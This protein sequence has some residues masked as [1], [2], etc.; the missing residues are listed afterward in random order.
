MS[1][2]AVTVAVGLLGWIAV[3]LDWA[4]LAQVAT[5]GAWVLIVGA[6]LMHLLTIPLK[7]GGWRC[8][9]AASSPDAA[10]VGTR[11]MLSPVMVGAL[12]NLV[13]P[14]RAGEPARILLLSSALRRSGRPIAMPVI[15]G[16][17]V[18]E[19]LVSTAAW[20]VLVAAAGVVLG[21]P[22]GVWLALVIL[23]AAWALILLASARDWWSVPASSA[24]G[25]LIGR[26]ISAVRGVWTS[27]ARGHRELRRPAVLVP[28]AAAGLGGWIAQWLSA[29]LLLR[30][31]G[32][33]G[34]W[35]A[36]TLVL[37]AA[38]LAQTIPLLPG[39]VGVFQAAVA[40]PL[41]TSFD[42][43]PATA[44]AFGVVLQLV[45]TLPVSV[46]GALA[47]GREGQGL[48][49]LYALVRRLPSRAG[50]APA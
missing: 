29:Y 24:S 33:D 14:G 27:V 42:V 19:S 49:S 45:Q 31:F 40:L 50:G 34:G 10:G 41:V 8:A 4:T 43:A 12:I 39:N 26:V 18:T 9:L 48:G 44:L 28:L 3:R 20:V 25:R 15:V 46:A 13:L 11:V 23:A 30:A 47:L 21:L 6:T 38:T 5:P 32:I 37:V 2:I 36:A 22:L 7:A 35:R 17:A 1:V 16:S